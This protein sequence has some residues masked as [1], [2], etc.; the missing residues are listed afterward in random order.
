MALRWIECDFSE[1]RE[2]FGVLNMPY[3]NSQ[4]A[5]TPQHSKKFMREVG[6]NVSTP[7]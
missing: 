6:A 4:D 5:C 1:M 3:S 2:R 7:V